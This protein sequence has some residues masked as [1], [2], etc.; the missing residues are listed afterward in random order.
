MTRRISWHYA[1]TATHLTFAQ[2]QSA[3]AIR[4]AWRRGMMRWKDFLDVRLATST[5]FDFHVAGG[6][7]NRQNAWAIAKISQRS[8]VMNTAIQ[9]YGLK[10]SLNGVEIAAP[11]ESG[12]I[13]LTSRHLDE[14]PDYYGDRRFSHVMK[15]GAGSYLF[16]PGAFSP[17]EVGLALSKGFRLNATPTH[18]YAKVHVA[19]LKRWSQQLT[20]LK[21]RLAKTTGAAREKLRNQI[22]AINAK[23]SEDVALTKRIVLLY[24]FHRVM[25][26]WQRRQAIVA[27]R[28]EADAA[29]VEQTYDELV[30]EAIDIGGRKASTYQTCRF[31][32]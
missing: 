29:T 10:W 28:D 21:E 17:P 30:R 31:D 16:S 13:F 12:H 9:A 25:F 2:P 32:V 7:I 14:L 15:A 24:P 19:N 18:P 3:E 4:A 1:P 6:D 26:A 20:T 22:A 8:I 27:A 5:P 11:H 23:R